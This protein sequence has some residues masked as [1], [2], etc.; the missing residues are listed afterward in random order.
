MKKD[1]W[2]YKNRGICVYC[3]NEQAT[4]GVACEECR[5]NHRNRRRKRVKEFLSVG[6]CPQCGFGQVKKGSICEGCKY[7]NSQRDKL[8]RL[9]LKE[10]GLCYWCKK[11]KEDKSK[12]LC[13]S[14]GDRARKYAYKRYIELREKENI[15]NE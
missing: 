7:E 14:C 11:E 15:K 8:R 13:Y 4:H 3:K 2:Y 1:Y 12:S 10:K 6:I 5:I 9:E